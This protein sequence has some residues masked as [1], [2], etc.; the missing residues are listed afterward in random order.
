VKL[1]QLRHRLG[2]KGLG[3]AAQP[4]L[5]AIFVEIASSAHSTAWMFSRT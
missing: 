1:S 3:D 4:P 2:A 5:K